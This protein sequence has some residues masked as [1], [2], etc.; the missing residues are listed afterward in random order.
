MNSF[1]SFLV[2]SFIV[3][4]T[5]ICLYVSLIYMSHSLKVI[6][7]KDTNLSDKKMFAAEKVYSFNT[8][9]IILDVA[10]FLRSLF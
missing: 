1:L 5:S 9:Q 3:G 6:Y 8:Y 4:F 10:S 7:S 2:K